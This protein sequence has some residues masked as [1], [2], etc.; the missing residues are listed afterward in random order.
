[1]LFRH[2]RNLFHLLLFFTLLLTQSCT[3]V[4]IGATA[5]TV[6]TLSSQEKSIGVIIDDRSIWTKIKIALSK[7]TLLKNVSIS[8]SEGRVLIT[9]KAK[10]SMERIKIAKIVWEQ[11]GVRE[12]MNET[13]VEL[14]EPSFSKSAWITSYIK[15]MLLMK[16]S[17]KSFNYTIET[18][19][20]TV[21]ILG[22]AQS[23]EEM[24]KVYTI[25][26]KTKGV[27]QVVNYARLKNSLMRHM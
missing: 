18:Y 23:K 14:H 20:G 13:Q 26:R 25:A 11:N 3:P 21:Y 4:V 17:I 19:D 15:L 10:N 24:K 22:I 12:V 8:V 1:M 27:K 7:E 5:A 9:G 2:N 16:N 6:A